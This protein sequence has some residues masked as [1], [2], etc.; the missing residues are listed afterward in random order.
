[1]GRHT[2]ARVYEIR[3]NDLDELK[4]RPIEVWSGLHQNSVDSAIG[5]WSK[6]PRC[7][8]TWATFRTFTADL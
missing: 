6:R 4:L 5:E 1:M 8:R 3:V 7:S 2:A